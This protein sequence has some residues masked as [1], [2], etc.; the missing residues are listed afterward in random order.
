MTIPDGKFD[1]ILCDPPWS[2]HGQQDKWGAA[3]KF[4]PTMTDSDLESLKVGDLAHEKSALFMWV[5]CPRLDFGVD[6]LRKWG[7]HYRGVAFVW[8][9]TNQEG[10]PIGAQGVR[11]S[12][13]K[14]LTELVIVG[15]KQKSGR[16][17]KLHSESI[18]QTVF[19]PRQEH[20]RKPDEVMLRIEAMYPTASKIE[21]FAR[22]RVDGWSAWGNEV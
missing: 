12:F 20:S 19:A 7:F 14:P 17:M 8:V 21:L 16:P 6:L 22:R 4:Y 1:V 3:A 2:Y 15:S 5:T 10:K 13:V 18:C 9:K 11:P